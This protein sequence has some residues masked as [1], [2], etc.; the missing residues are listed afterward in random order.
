[1]FRYF[2]IIVLLSTA[3]TVSAQHPEHFVWTDSCMTNYVVRHLDSTYSQEGIQESIMK[4]ASKTMP[5]PELDIIT[6]REGYIQLRWMQRGGPYAMNVFGFHR[7]M[8]T[9]IEL[10]IDIREGRYKIN[11]RE[12]GPLISDDDDDWRN[13]A[14]FGAV[15]GESFGWGIYSPLDKDGVPIDKRM[16]Y[17]PE[18]VEYFE[19]L[20]EDI[21]NAVTKSEAESNGEDW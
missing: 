7:S 11:I 4:W 3:T 21:F 10:S 18:I 12:I 1:M 19:R 20:N 13:G 14:M 8:H 9:K 16:K 5:R 6:E 2:Q 17:F 15:Y